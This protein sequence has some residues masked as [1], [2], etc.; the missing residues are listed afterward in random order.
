MS[1]LS[2]ITSGNVGKVGSD[3]AGAV[4]NPF[5]PIGTIVAPNFSPNLGKI[6]PSMVGGQTAAQSAVQNPWTSPVNPYATG[7]QGSQGGG[8]QVAQG[9]PVSP[10]FT[11]VYNTSEALLPGYQAQVAGND[12]GF[13]AYKAMALQPRR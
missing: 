2:D 10:G 12:A 13:N 3:V 6:F 5:G 7:T 1:W 8:A 11:N 9:A 4:A